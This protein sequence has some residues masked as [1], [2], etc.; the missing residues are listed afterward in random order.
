MSYS[1]ITTIRIDSQQQRHVE[2]DSEDEVVILE[3]PVKIIETISLTDSE[4]EQD[5]N[6][7]DQGSIAS[8]RSSTAQNQA[9]ESTADCCS[10]KEATPTYSNKSESSL[11]SCIKEEREMDNHAVKNLFNNPYVNPL[12]GKCRLFFKDIMLF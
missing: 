9:K 11:N 12:L 4:D 10:K 2:S 3:T 6:C 8:A 5:C 1:K 7:I